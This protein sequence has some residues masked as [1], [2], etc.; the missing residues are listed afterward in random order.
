MIRIASLTPEQYARWDAFV[1]QCPEATFFHRAGWKEVLE[2]ALRHDT[3]FLYAEENGEILGVLPLAHVRSRL[4]GNALSSLAFCVYGGIAASSEEARQALEQAAVAK[5]E[6][7]GVDFLEMRYRQAQREDWPRKSL[8]YTFRKAIDP[9]VEQNL[10]NIPRKQRA[11][12]RKGIKAGLTSEWD[13]GIDRFYEAYAR[14]LHALGTP[15]FSRRYFQSLREVFGGDC[16]VLTVTHEG[17]LIASVMSFYFRDEVLP[18]YGGGTARA[19]AVK[20]NDFMYWELMRRSCEEGLKVFDYGR[21]KAGTGSFSFKKN[22]GFEPEP[23]SYEYHLVKAKALPDI[24]PKNPKYRFFISAW[25]K[26]PFA[27]TKILGPHIVRQ[28]TG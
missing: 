1:M 11:M 10:K 7:L 17:E 25:Q 20:G 18:Y 21:S 5:A 26:L 12:V 3:Y 28:T 22:W 2:R 23:L 16:R 4:F 27:A 14:S 19:R 6:A 9:D 8:Y 13:D 15:V 24:N